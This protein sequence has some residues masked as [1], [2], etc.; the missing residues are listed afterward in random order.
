MSL[1]VP[2]LQ[3][4]HKAHSSQREEET[5]AIELARCSKTLALRSSHSVRNVSMTREFASFARRFERARTAPG[6]QIARVLCAVGEGTA[7]PI[8]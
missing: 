6:H 7:F 4:S 1:K 3:L 5:V 2:R 8:S